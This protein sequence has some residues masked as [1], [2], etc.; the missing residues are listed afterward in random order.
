MCIMRKLMRQ[1]LC[2]GM[3]SLMLVSVMAVTPVLAFG[4]EENFTTI[5]Q[6]APYDFDEPDGG[7]DRP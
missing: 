6:P 7:D 5:V 2:F 3:S 1:V 4:Y